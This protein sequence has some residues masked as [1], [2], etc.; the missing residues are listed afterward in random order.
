MARRSRGFRSKTRKLLRIRGKKKV[1]ITAQLRTF[2][3]GETAVVKIDPSLQA[4][5]PHPRFYG[6]SG[7]VIEKR[8]RAYVLEIKDRGKTKKL[9]AGPAHLKKISSPVAAK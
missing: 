1:P 6:K 5:S 8:G 4:A 3:V 2:K 9:I 7:V